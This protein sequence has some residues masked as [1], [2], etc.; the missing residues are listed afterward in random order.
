MTTINLTPSLMEV[1]KRLSNIEKG[2]NNENIA[3]SVINEKV[4]GVFELT[5]LLLSLQDLPE[6][7]TKNFE[8]DIN[9]WN[10]ENISSNS[11]HA[12]ILNLF[13]LAKPNK[14]ESS[15]SPMTIE[16]IS[17]LLSGRLTGNFNKGYKGVE[18]KRMKEEFDDFVVNNRILEDQDY[19]FPDNL[20]PV[21][22]HL[23]NAHRMKGYTF[24]S[25]P[26]FALT[27]YKNMCQTFLDFLLIVNGLSQPFPIHDIK[28][29]TQELNKL[30]RE[31][32]EITNSIFFQMN[33]QAAH[34]KI[35]KDWKLTKQEETMMKEELEKKFLI[36]N[37]K[38]AKILEGLK[39]KENAIKEGL[40]N[41]N[42]NITKLFESL[43]EK[44]LINTR[45]DSLSKDRNLD[46]EDDQLFFTFYKDFCISTLHHLNH[47][48]NQFSTVQTSFKNFIVKGSV[49]SVKF[50]GITNTKDKKIKT[51]DKNK[52]IAEQNPI[53]EKDNLTQILNLVST[54]LIFQIDFM[55]DYIIARLSLEEGLLNSKK[56]EIIAIDIQQLA[57]LSLTSYKSIKNEFWKEDSILTKNKNLLSELNVEDPDYVHID[58]AYEWLTDAKRKFEFSPLVDCSH[59][60]SSYID[61]NFFNELEQKKL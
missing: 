24:K 5:Y 27:M 43:Y 29:N 8:S 32:T 35:N 59:V 53:N 56:G 12:I 51:S 40:I 37:Q 52:K 19:I 42:F 34:K 1:L 7:D 26:K 23:I 11:L 4:A 10:D 6:T 48:R 13:I 39:I 28:N 33:K 31:Q 60:I 57:Y 22:N 45:P 55:T 3:G 54:S 50:D 49:K 58:D 61:L 15:L 18:F 44:K 17:E 9:S 36:K 16:Y 2:L 25:N 38:S 20:P 46:I 47:L 21:K 30:F 41:E 14:L